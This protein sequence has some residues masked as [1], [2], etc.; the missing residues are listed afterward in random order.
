MK[1]G[2]WLSLLGATLLFG[3]NTLKTHT[4]LSY[5][6]TQGNTDTNAFSLDFA[7]AK[8]WGAHTAKL[9]FDALYGTDNGIETRNKITTE[10]NCDYRFNEHFALNYLLGYKNDKFSG[11]DYQF[12]TG[13]GI[14]AILLDSTQHK[15]NVQANVLY[16]V[17]ETMDKY[18]NADGAEI[19][20]P[21][22]DGKAGAISKIEG[23]SDEYTGYALKTDYTWQIRENLKF[24]QEASYRG[25]FEDSKRYFVCS[26]T[27]LESKISSIFS[28]GLSYKV[29][30]TNLPPA[31][32]EYTDRT[33]MTSL[34]IDY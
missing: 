7:G 15:L 23:E 19:T 9:D 31:G 2:L 28:L 33:F 13:P 10:F 34:I 20:Y 17:D 24:L 26:K 8:S 25:D 27:A 4:E 6:N 30:Y 5:V 11:F 16:S 1:K 22:P 32:N 14:K 12:Y 3:D 18:Y 21:Y 29:D